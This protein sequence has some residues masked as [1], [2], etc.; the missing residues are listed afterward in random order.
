[1]VTAD[2]IKQTATSQEHLRHALIARYDELVNS[3]IMVKTLAKKA[4]VKL[5]TMCNTIA[6]LKAGTDIRISSLFKLAKILD[7]SIK[8]AWQPL[9]KRKFKETL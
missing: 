5:P 9:P 7:I 2:T 8:L 4:G 1:M 3:G 6:N